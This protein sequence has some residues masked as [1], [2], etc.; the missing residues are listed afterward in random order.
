MQ[1]TEELKRSE[2]EQLDFTKENEV[3]KLDTC[4]VSMDQIW[5]DSLGDL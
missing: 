5:Y 4:T 3:S 1:L 2:L